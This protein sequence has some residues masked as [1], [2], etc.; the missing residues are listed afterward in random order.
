MR[1]LSVIGSCPGKLGVGLLPPVIRWR[2]RTSRS[3]SRHGRDLAAGSIV[4]FRRITR[5]LGRPHRPKNRSLSLPLR[6]TRSPTS[7]SR[8]VSAASARRVCARS[9]PGSTA[10]QRT[11]RAD[12][13]AAS[14]WTTPLTENR[15]MSQAARPLK[16]MRRRRKRRWGWP[17]RRAAPHSIQLRSGA[18]GYG[19]CH[20][21]PNAPS[22]PGAGRVGWRMPARDL[23]AQ[24]GPLAKATNTTPRARYPTDDRS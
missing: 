11:G 4:G 12:A 8:S 7:G 5:G 20:T 21:K 18:I 22:R 1:G 23:C 9:C 3:P 19:D 15:P 14:R 10:P 2:T 16:G 17:L 24:T 6:R 13:P